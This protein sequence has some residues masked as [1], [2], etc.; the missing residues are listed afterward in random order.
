MRD[1]ATDIHPASQLL[2]P[3]SQT[4]DV[5]AMKRGAQGGS[6]WGLF[7]S[8]SWQWSPDSAGTQQEEASSLSS[9]AGHFHLGFPAVLEGASPS[10]MG[11]T[12]SLMRTETASG[13]DQDKGACL[14]ASK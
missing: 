6:F 4:W 12:Y 3:D 13:G 5:A 9:S 1:S 11:N 2:V 10:S 8:W 7:G 14:P